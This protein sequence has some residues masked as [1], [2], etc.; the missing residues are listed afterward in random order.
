[1][2]TKIL[3]HRFIP[4]IPRQ[5]QQYW[6]RGLIFQASRIENV[7]SPDMDTLKCVITGNAVFVSHS[8]Q[9][10]MLRL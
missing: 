3:L 5:N 10:A 7:P 6:Y 9:C 2:V 4:C 8:L 1:M